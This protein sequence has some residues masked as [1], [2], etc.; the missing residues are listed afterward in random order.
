MMHWELARGAKVLI[1]YLCNLKKGENVLIYT[2]TSGDLLAAYYIASATHA[3]EGVVSLVVYETPPEVDMEP[4][5]PLAAAMTRADLIIELAEKYLIHTRAYLEALKSARILCLTGMSCEMMYRCVSRVN[6][7]KMLELGKRLTNLLK[8]G[9]T[10]EIKT[11]AGTDLVCELGGRVE[12][13]AG[14]I[15]KAGEESYLG[16]QL[17]CY[18]VKDS[19]NGVIV[20]DGAVWPPEDL[21]VLREPIILKIR[22]GGIKK[23]EGGNAAARLRL[24]LKSFEDPKMFMIAHLSFGFNPGAR[25]T[26]KILEDERVFGCIEVGIGSQVPSFEVGLASAHTDGVILN[27]TIKLD[28]EVIEEEGCFVHLE[29]KKIAD[30]LI[31][32]IS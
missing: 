31:K 4:S 7:P 25:L 2:D 17:S 1:E 6:Y 27:P 23:I 28:N 24:W 8:Q 19:I 26:G 10:L 22:K 30:I 3:A 15:F 9:H 12:H 14:R 32:N 11:A 16:G 29:L 20:F 21:G 13:N 18:P 5:P